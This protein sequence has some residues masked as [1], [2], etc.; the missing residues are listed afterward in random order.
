MR[1]ADDRG[2]I[3]RAIVQKV[4]WQHHDGRAAHHVLHRREGSA[5]AAQL[6]LRRCGMRIG[7]E[8][9]AGVH[10]HA[11]LREQQRERQHMHEPAAIS[12]DQSGLRE[13]VFP[14]FRLSTS[15]GRRKLQR[16][17]ATD[18]RL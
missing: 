2:A 6:C 1:N 3:E 15:Y 11:E 7:L 5:L 17:N 16:C 10:H 12:S 18:L 8:V 14:A 13:G 4:N 9:A